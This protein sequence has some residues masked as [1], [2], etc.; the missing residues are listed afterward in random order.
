MWPV[1]MHINY[2]KKKLETIL[3]DPNTRINTNRLLLYTAKTGPTFFITF[4]HFNLSCT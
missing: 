4:A 3:N 2:F 1:G